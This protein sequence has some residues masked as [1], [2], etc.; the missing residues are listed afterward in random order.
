M[1]ATTPTNHK[2][3]SL[4]A[5]L[6]IFDTIFARTETNTRLEAGL[7]IFDAINAQTDTHTP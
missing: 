5:G 2:P 4:E 3:A 6:P 1:H 7:P